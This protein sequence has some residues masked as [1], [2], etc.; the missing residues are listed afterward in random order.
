MK[1]NVYSSSQLK[2]HGEVI[3]KYVKDSSIVIQ[4]YSYEDKKWIS[5]N[6]SVEPKFLTSIRYRIK[7][8]PVIKNMLGEIIAP[9]DNCFLVDLNMDGVSFKVNEYEIT[10][11]NIEELLDSGE[12]DFFIGL[13]VESSLRLALQAFINNHVGMFL[14]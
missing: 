13:S 2:V 6:A 9:G 12:D 4:S 14:K 10:E 11:S 5:L 1:D 3:V 8:L 7:P